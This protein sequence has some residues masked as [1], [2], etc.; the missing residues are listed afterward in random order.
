MPPPSES[1]SESLALPPVLHV[2]GAAVA[3]IGDEVHCTVRTHCGKRITLAF[4][5]AFAA[6]TGKGMRLAGLL[7]GGRVRRRV[8]G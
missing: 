7:T 2:L 8:T 5:P 4:S 6:E 1:R 3:S